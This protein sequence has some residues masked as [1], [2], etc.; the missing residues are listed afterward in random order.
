MREL[1]NIYIINHHLH[2]GLDPFPVINI[3]F[4][5]IPIPKLWIEVETFSTRFDLRHASYLDLGLQ[6]TQM[7]IF[8]C[9]STYLKDKGTKIFYTIIGQR[10]KDFL[11]ICLMGENF[12]TKLKSAKYQIHLSHIIANSDVTKKKFFSILKQ[13]KDSSVCKRICTQETLHIV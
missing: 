13:S 1:D 2:N 3:C 5:I 11:V 9:S 4:H 6:P 7:K 8:E 12:S 10:D